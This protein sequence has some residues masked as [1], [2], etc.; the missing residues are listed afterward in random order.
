MLIDKKRDPEYLFAVIVPSVLYGIVSSLFLF[1]VLPLLILA[2]VFGHSRVVQSD[3]ELKFLLGAALAAT[4]V[5][6]SLASLSMVLPRGIAYFR[7]RPLLKSAVI[8][9]IL[10]GC[11]L[12]GV[13]LV[14][15][16]RSL[17]PFSLIYIVSPGYS[18]L[19]GIK[20]VVFLLLNRSLSGEE[21]D[22]S[23]SQQE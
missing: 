23:A 14:L 5:L 16:G 2:E 6:V 19:I 7:E 15:A 8:I 18:L 22:S 1:F 9:G 13:I 17:W 4:V 12:S 20:A 11:L 3:T 10:L 21:E